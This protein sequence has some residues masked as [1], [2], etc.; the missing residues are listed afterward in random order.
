MKEEGL[1]CSWKG[2]CDI[3]TNRLHTTSSFIA[4]SLE[5]VL[6]LLTDYF[7]E[8]FWRIFSFSISGL[9][10][11][12]LPFCSIIYSRTEMV[13]EKKGGRPKYMISQTIFGWLYPYIAGYARGNNETKSSFSGRLSFST[14]SLV[15]T[16]SWVKFEPILPARSL[17]CA[18]L[19]CLCPFLLHKGWVRRREE[20]ACDRFIAI[21]L[22]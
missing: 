18:T 19:S 6:N 8:L 20:C 2:V 7:K 3:T 10:G 22:R 13:C 11:P 15:L 4:T 12:V 21:S 1:G 5:A 9:S 16:S 14:C 17:T